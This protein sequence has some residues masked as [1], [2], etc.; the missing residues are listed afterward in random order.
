MK[1]LILIM[2]LLYSTA[3]A[4]HISTEAERNMKMYCESLIYQIPYRGDADS[5]YHGLL[6]G[7]VEMAR[8]TNEIVNK[9][10]VVHGNLNDIVIHVCEVTIKEKPDRIGF[11]L[12]YQ[13]FALRE[14]KR[15]D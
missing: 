13:I 5:L 2:S 1:K 14:T 12:A 7:Y 9:Y 4:G 10:K 3:F 15:E 6:I 8:T 11:R